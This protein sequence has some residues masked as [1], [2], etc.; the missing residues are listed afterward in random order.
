MH[1]EDSLSKSIR[2]AF[3]PVPKEPEIRQ[4]CPQN[5][6]VG[7]RKAEKQHTN[8]ITSE[9]PES[10]RSPKMELKIIAYMSISI[11]W[12]APGGSRDARDC[13]MYW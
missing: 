7:S 13:F 5:P 6:Y 9:R 8:R 10:G 4:K 2:L 11:T 1:S 12:G 3:L